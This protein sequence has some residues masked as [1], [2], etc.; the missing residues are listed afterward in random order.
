MSH[1][2]IT[3]PMIK[4]IDLWYQNGTSRFV[5]LGDISKNAFAKLAFFHYLYRFS[6]TFSAILAE[7]ASKKFE[8]N[9]IALHS[10]E[11]MQ[12]TYGFQKYLNMGKL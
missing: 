7:C 11:I 3:K 5:S 10:S 2:I 1:K 6:E 4:N 9:T 12:K 8:T